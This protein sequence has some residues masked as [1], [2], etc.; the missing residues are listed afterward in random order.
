MIN[1][2]TMVGRLTRDAE[3]KTVGASN[4]ANAKLGL[5]VSHEQKTKDGEIKKE[6]CFIDCIL[7]RQEADKARDLKKG[8]EVFVTGRLKLE[9]WDD[10]NQKDKD[11]NPVKR[12]KHVIQVTDII[13]N[14]KL[15]D[16]II[17]QT[18]AAMPKQWKQP[19]QQPV[20]PPVSQDSDFEEL[21]F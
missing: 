19:Q 10:K 21:P 1:Q 17:E 2:I 9:Q 3:Y 20:R 7:W 11:G 13:Y 14:Y 4:I 6:V 18:E 8:M 15:S 16:S 12:S 5:A